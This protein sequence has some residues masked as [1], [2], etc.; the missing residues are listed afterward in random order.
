MGAG[1]QELNKEQ[2]QR[3]EQR[4]VKAPAGTVTLQAPLFLRLDLQPIWGEGR[5]SPSYK[6]NMA[7]VEEHSRAP[8]AWG[9]R[10][11]PGRQRP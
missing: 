2:R 9:P 8:G 7:W 5:H 6:G 4:S 10:L 3:P 11:E 1:R